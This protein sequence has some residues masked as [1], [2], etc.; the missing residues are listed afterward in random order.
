MKYGAMLEIREDQSS[1]PGG[2]IN[3]SI[4][5]QDRSRNT[6]FYRQQH[7]YVGAD[8]LGYLRLGG[9]PGAATLLST[10]TFE[11]FNDGGWNGD[12]FV[13]FTTN[14]QVVWPFSTASSYYGTNKLTYVSPIFAGADFSISFEPS[15]SNGT[16]SIGNCPYGVTANAGINGPI[17]GGLAAL[18]CD[19]ASSTST[20]D[21]AR[22]RNT[23]EA[24]AR[25][26]AAVGAFGFAIAG[27]TIFSGRVADNA[28][29]ARAVQF[30]DQLIG[31]G[32]LDVT[33]GGL[34]VGGH[35]TG[36]R[37]NGSLNTLLPEG[38]RDE[39]VWLVGASYAY[40]PFIV[41]ASY[42]DIMSAGS[43]TAATSPFVGNRNE[44]G[45]A[46][47]GTYNFAPGMNIFLTYLYGHR[48]QLGVDFLSGAV[49]SG[50]T[51]VTTHNNVQSQGFALGTQF[52]W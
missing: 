11:N 36:G 15:A 46:A 23:V 38:Q 49:S 13:F 10:G 17:S 40:G 24:F 8:K 39:F 33:Y 45:V 30:R 50:A 52:R 34:T 25:Y 19:T 1:P 48:K 4:S 44:Y 29:P 41:G 37:V 35:I 9:A 26:R 6:I 20:G 7:M 18:G 27:G 42:Y 2:G 31:D 47:G 43:K 21:N 32:G 5:A 51:Q 28:T 22:R 12:V 14:T 16:G 3:G